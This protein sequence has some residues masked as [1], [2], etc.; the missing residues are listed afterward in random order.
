MLSI[1]LHYRESVKISI[2]KVFETSQNKQATYSNN[3]RM[4]AP[5]PKTLPVVDAWK[6]LPLS[7]WR[8]EQAAHLLR[9]IGFSTML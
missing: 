9:R 3:M 1:I 2:F 8:E 4:K 5:T 6:P 7:H